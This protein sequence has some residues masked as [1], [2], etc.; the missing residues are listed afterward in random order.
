MDVAAGVVV[1]WS[2]VV[3]AV[4]VVILSA[5]WDSCRALRAVSSR[6]CCSIC[7]SRPASSS[8]MSAFNYDCIPAN[9]SILAAT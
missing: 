2:A 3:E 9:S 5:R 6:L 4:V 1:P 8:S 7:S